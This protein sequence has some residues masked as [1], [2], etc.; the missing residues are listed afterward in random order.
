MLTR[1]CEAK[2]NPLKVLLGG[3]CKTDDKTVNAVLLFYYSLRLFVSSYKEKD[4]ER[5]DRTPPRVGGRGSESRHLAALCCERLG[6]SF[7]CSLRR[8]PPRSHKNKSTESWRS[9]HRFDNSRALIP[10]DCFKSDTSQ[11]SMQQTKTLAIK[12]ESTLL[13]QM[14]LILK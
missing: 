6:D 9:T 12:T 1:A 5:G 14:V 13:L 3:R 4:A 8:M 7:L 2:G 11:R 10:G